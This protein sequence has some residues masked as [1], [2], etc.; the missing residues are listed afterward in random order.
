MQ[1]SNDALSRISA[2]EQPYGQQMLT[3]KFKD[4]NSL[5]GGLSE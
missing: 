4:G 5:R 1:S 2:G 3:N